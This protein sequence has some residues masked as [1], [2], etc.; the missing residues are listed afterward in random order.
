MNRPGH[1]MNYLIIFMT[2]SKSRFLVFNAVY[3]FSIFLKVDVPT[4]LDLVERLLAYNPAQ[5]LSALQ[6]IEAPYFTQEAPAAELPK[7]YVQLHTI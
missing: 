5:R 3:I 6:A 7:G 2:C 1:T 4:A